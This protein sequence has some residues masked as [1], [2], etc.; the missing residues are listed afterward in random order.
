MVQKQA[1]V[2]NPWLEG[3]RTLNGDEVEAI[4]SRIEILRIGTHNVC[5]GW[6]DGEDCRADQGRREG[7]PKSVFRPEQFDSCQHD[8]EL[9]S[10]HN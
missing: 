1:Y 7:S 10:V 8:A 9:V 2:E 3:F 6:S 5:A 4:G